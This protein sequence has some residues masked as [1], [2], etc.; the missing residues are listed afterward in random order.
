[1]YIVI[2]G[3]NCRM[4]CRY[5]DICKEYGC[6]AKIFTQPR[7]DLDYNIGNPDLIVL[8]TNPVA[9]VMAQAARRKSSQNG[10]ALTQSHSASDN[11]LRHILRMHCA[12]KR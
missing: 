10:I 8:F 7:A 12:M 4:H 6:R 11:A 9:H 3:G 1:M 2:I 5:K